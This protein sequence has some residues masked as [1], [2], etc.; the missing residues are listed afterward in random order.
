MNPKLALRLLV[1]IIGLA[2][3]GGGLRTLLRPAEY[4]ATV[5]I[6]IERDVITD[7]PNEQSYMP[8][9]PY[10]F[11]SELKAIQSDAV[12][13]NVVD[14]LN[15]ETEWGKRYGSGGALETDEATELL[16]RHMDLDVVPNTKIIDISAWDENPDEVAR[17]ANAIADAYIK[18]RHERHKEQMENGIKL[19]EKQYQEEEAKIWLM[20]SNVDQLR[21]K[22]DIIETNRTK[23]MSA[24]VGKGQPFWQAKTQL[25]DV[26][27]LHKMLGERIKADKADAANPSIVL[28]EIINPAIAPTVPARPNRWLGAG[29]LACGL[30]ISVFGLC[31]LRNGGIAKVKP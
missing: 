11:E 9:D 23:D 14:A 10:F 13:S 20:Q 2:L 26:Q 1:L 29:M 19:L 22:L 15:L 24:S 8:Y 25:Q 12:L 18:Y 4:R 3:C 27:E 21:K 17:I 6:E 7:G 30:V 31:S 16:R 28:A 5:Q